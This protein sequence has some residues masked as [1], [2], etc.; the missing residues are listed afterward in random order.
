MFY[1]KDKTLEPIKFNGERSVNGIINWIKDKTQ[2]DWIQPENIKEVTKEEE[3]EYLE[4][5]REEMGGEGGDH[6]YG[7]EL[8]PG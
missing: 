5:L 1:R 4:K 6:N 8:Q 2:Y 7:E 3:D